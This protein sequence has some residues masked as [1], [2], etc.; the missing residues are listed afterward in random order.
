MLAQTVKIIWVQFL[1]EK[2][3]DEK[4]ILEFTACVSEFQLKSD[5]IYAENLKTS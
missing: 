4:S 1:S 3:L 5:S 2:R